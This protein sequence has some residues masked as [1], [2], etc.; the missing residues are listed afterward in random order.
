[1]KEL[2]IIL[3]LLCAGISAF[4][5]PKAKKAPASKISPVD[6]NLSTDFNFDGSVVR[7]KYQM[8]DEAVT[9]VE[10]EKTLDDLLGVRKNFKD[11]LQLEENRK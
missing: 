1:M 11:R 6:P 8:A 10:N 2:I 9:V 7:G 5:A 3:A 4:A